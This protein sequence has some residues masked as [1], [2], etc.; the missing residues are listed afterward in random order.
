MPRI[1]PVDY[2]T[3]LKVFQAFGCQYKRKEG[4]H[5]VLTYSGARRAV[6]IPEYDE[7]DVDIIK[8]NMRTVEMAREQYFE[9]LQKVK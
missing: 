2:R 8:N 5:H 1:T 3:L 6:V 4:S 7:V 9:L